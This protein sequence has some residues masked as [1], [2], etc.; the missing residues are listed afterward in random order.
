MTKPSDPVSKRRTIENS[1]E[2]PGSPEQVWRAIASGPGISC[3]FMPAELAEHEGGSVAFDMGSGMAASGVVTKWDPPRRL[4]YEE[5]WTGYDGASIGKLA[6]E[7]TVEPRGGGTCVVRLVSNLFTSTGDWDEELDDLH[8]GWN[9]YFEVLRLYLVHFA[10]QSCGTILV[11]GE[12]SG[13]KTEAYAA[14]T[15]A[16][17]LGPLASGQAVQSGPEAPRLAGT[18]ERLGPREALLRLSEPAAGSAL[19]FAYVN[20]DKAIVN[21]HAYLYGEGARAIAA[22]ETPRWQSFMQQ[23]FPRR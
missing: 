21:V 13:S 19:V 18:V 10:G 4:A 15:D 1:I 12:A 20:G 17:R 6:S 16:L 7:F 23:R 3:W 11:T 22:R 2:V 9:T 8:K 5:E 14:L